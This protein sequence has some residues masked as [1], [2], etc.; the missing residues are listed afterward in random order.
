M[1]IYEYRPAGEGELRMPAQDQ[2]TIMDNG[3]G[4]ALADGI[5]ASIAPYHSGGM[6]GIFRKDEHTKLAYFG[7][8]FRRLHLESTYLGGCGIPE[9]KDAQTEE[10]YAAFA[11]EQLAHF[12]C[13]SQA[14]FAVRRVAQSFLPY[15]EVPPNY[16]RLALVVNCPFLTRDPRLSPVIKDAGIVL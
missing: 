13:S 9:A 3:G 2:M 4:T 11:L 16:T 10:M 6:V 12:I 1:L 15:G 14:L 8:Q 7:R 5:A